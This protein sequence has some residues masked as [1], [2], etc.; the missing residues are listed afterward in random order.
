MF[1]LAERA[2]QV[3]YELGI[4][5]TLGTPLLLLAPADAEIPFDVA[6]NVNRYP[7]ECD[8]D[9]LLGEQLDVAFYG[10]QVRGSRASGLAATLAYAERLAAEHDNV[11]LGVVLESLRRAD[12][13][14]V[15][16]GDALESVNSYL[17]HAKLE[18]VLPCWPGGYPNPA[19]PSWFAV[20]PFR[21]E[22]ETAY[23]AM[24]D[25]AI[26]AGITPVRGDTA[27]GQEIIESIWQELCRATHVTV[28]LSGFN[29]N[30][31]L[32]L[33]IAHTLGRPVLLVGEKGTSQRLAE[34]LPT[35]AKWRCHTYDAAPGSQASF[36]TVVQGFFQNSA[37]RR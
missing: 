29:L 35:V 6:Q 3:Y 18:I 1:D 28:D 5:L 9:G 19:A 27:G 10:S 4:A 15:R 25:A 37:P 14:P 13:D 22:R 24:R 16:F 32:E 11:L 36:R 20:M 33:G 30:V 17:G 31:C 2:P 21:A 8:L 12:S 7:P 23:E 34:A 26:A